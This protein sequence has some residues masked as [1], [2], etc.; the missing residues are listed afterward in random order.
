MLRALPPAAW[1]RLLKPVPRLGAIP[2]A[3]DKIHKLANILPLGPDGAFRRL[4]SEW[5]DPEG[6]VTGGRENVH[7]VW[8]EAGALVPDFVERMQYIDTLTYLP[9]D[10]LT[11]VDRASM[12]VSLEARVPL[13]DHRVVEF[14]WS[15]PP[16]L[17]IR[18]REGKWILRQVLYR[19]VPRELIER[20]KMGFGVPIDSWLRG[21]LRGWA[22]DLLSEDRLRRQGFLEPAPI[23]RRWAEHLSGTRN[24]QYSLWGVL[25]FNAWVEHAGAGRSISEKPSQPQF[26]S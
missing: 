24:W 1:S 23:R 26:I 18:G 14:A 16:E 19:H 13:L 20:P 7:P 21:P 6:L 10:I 22:E 4:V 3:G 11:K 25:M 12:A 2:M 17:K 8:R 5:D 9:D 15:L